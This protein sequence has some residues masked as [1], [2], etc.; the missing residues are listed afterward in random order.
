LEALKRKAALTNSNSPIIDYVDSGIH[1][2][3]RQALLHSSH[4]WNADIRHVLRLCG[5]TMLWPRKFTVCENPVSDSTAL[6]PEAIDRGVAFIAEQVNANRKV[7]VHCVAGISSSPAFVLA[8][9]VSRGDDIREAWQLLKRQHSTTSPHPALITSLI[10]H[11]SLPY[12]LADL[13]DLYQT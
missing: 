7:L 4:V 6:P 3:S 8:Y 2:S 11:Y 1:I 5:D 13:I 12:T 9:F 10:R